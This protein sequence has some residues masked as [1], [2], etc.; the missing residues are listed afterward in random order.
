MSCFYSNE[1]DCKFLNIEQLTAISKWKSVY[2][3]EAKE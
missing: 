3:A 2:A 1:R